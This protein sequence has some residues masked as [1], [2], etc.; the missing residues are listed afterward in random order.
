MNLRIRAFP[1]HGPLVWYAVGAGV[2]A[3]TFHLVFFAS[4]V[5]LVH[6]HGYFWL[7]YVGNGISYAVTFV[8]LALSIVMIR[9]G[10]DSEDAG[11]VAGRIRFLGI[12]ALLSNSI[13]LML[14][15][16][17]AVYALVLNTGRA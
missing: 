12:V 8:A 2:A 3:W 11:T 16:A 10:T 6:D 17:E 14:I 7:F 5:E 4:I 15:T 1:D 13:N 9:A